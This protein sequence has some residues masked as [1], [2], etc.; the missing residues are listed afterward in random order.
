MASDE[1]PYL[2]NDGEIISFFLD[3][4]G[5]SLRKVISIQ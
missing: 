1:I 5:E 3:F 4:S 2:M